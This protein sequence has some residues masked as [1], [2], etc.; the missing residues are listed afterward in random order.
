M[1]ASFSSP[2]G[3]SGLLG[4]LRTSTAAAAPSGRALVAS[5][6]GCSLLVATLLFVFQPIANGH[7][8]QLGVRVTAILAAIWMVATYRGYWLSERKFLGLAFVAGLYCCVQRPLTIK[9]S[10]EIIAAYG[11]AFAALDAGQN[12]YTSGTI[13]HHDEHGQDKLGNFN[14]PPV[15]LL[16]YYGISKLVGRWDHAVLT[17]TLLLFQLAACG[18]LYLT[19]RRPAAGENEDAAP[20]RGSPGAARVTLA[21]APL[22]TCFELHTNVALTLFGVAFAVYLLCSRQSVDTGLRSWLLWAWFGV[23]LLTKFLVIPLFATYA[24]HVV[25]FRSW[26]AL[27]ASLRGPCLSL[28]LCVLLMLPFGIANVLRETLLFNLVLSQRA[29]L[30]TFYPNV[31]SGLSSWLGIP[32]AFPVLAVLLLGGAVLY[33]RRFPLLHAMFFTGSVFLLVSPTPEP[34]YIPVMLF[35]ALSAQLASPIASGAFS[36]PDGDGLRT[37]HQ[38]LAQRGTQGWRG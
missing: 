8:Y 2:E 7:S 24:L 18:L 10:S 34:Q 31:L 25:S 5:M 30:T 13:V 1:T 27:G 12:P 35:L 3:S 14:Y 32:G 26:R 17:G 22:L 16:P 28:A 29:P 11:S 6:F 9:P 38:A 37:R 4:R 33:A 36:Q 20:S 21:F 15:E 19:F 23:A